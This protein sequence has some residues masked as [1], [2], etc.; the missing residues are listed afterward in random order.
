MK[1]FSFEKTYVASIVKRPSSQIRS[2]YVSDVLIEDA[3][4]PIIAHSP[5]LGCCGLVDNGS[6]V[7][8]TKKCNSK[9]KCKYQV[10][11][12]T[13]RSKGHLVHIGVLPKSAEHIAHKAL[14]HGLVKD[15]KVIHVETEKCFLNSRFDFY[16]ITSDNNLFVCEVKTVPLADYF[17][18]TAKER[19]Q[20]DFSQCKYNEKVAYFPDG[21]R[22]LKTDP[23]SPRATKH[24]HELA[25]LKTMYPNWRCILL[26]VIQRKDVSSFQP[27]RLDPVY[28]D[29]VRKAVDKGV[30]VKT[31]QV[32]WTPH[33]AYYV[34][35]DLPI[36]I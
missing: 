12:A 14:L 23:V 24:V 27:S 36:H 30:E 29:A 4:S 8:V 6:T 33:A 3:V 5:S 19:K 17:D 20:M 2:P 28:V 13:I 11:L 9:A 21:Y 18:G 26:F 25:Q 35:N 10:V 15:L 22:K 32:R 1:L 7:R 31:L 16:G 34:R